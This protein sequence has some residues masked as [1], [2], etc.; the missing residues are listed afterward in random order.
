MNSKFLALI[1]TFNP[2]LERLNQCV[3]SI[4]N[5]V[6]KILIVD[7]GSKNQNS[8]SKFL[9][10]F[11]NIIF[12][13]KETNKGLSKNYNEGI[14][15]A[16]EN[17]YDFLLIL[18]QDT[19]CEKN[20]IEEVSKHSNDEYAVFVPFKQHRNKDYQQ[21]LYRISSEDRHHGNA[22]VVRTA[23][24]SGTCINLHT[25][26]PNFQF[27][28]K[29]FVDCI[30]WDFYLR[31]QSAG[32]KTLRV[33]TTRIFVEIGNTTKHKFFSY[34]WFAKNYSPKRLKISARDFVVFIKSNYKI[35][36]QNLKPHIIYMLWTYWMIMFEKN[37]LKKYFEVL[38][39]LFLGIFSKVH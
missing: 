11:E 9:T 16:R 1:V 38:Q 36:W 35:G 8:I 24:N 19:I 4:A 25:L 14:Q 22:E 33:N 2:D 7:N 21:H 15:F 13:K 30:D 37:R 29:L 3:S 20:L 18:D 32:F 17:N 39:G 12:F 31:L 5:Q 26:P 23:I 10:K 6:D 27:N 28:E 34:T